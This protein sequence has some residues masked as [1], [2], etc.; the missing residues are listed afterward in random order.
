MK[1]F[2]FFFHFCFLFFVLLL[3]YF[4]DG[5]KVYCCWIR[6]LVMPME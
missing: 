6:V 5:L 3:V 2:F 1:T 4:D